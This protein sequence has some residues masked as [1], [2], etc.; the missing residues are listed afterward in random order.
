MKNIISPRRLRDVVKRAIFVCLTEAERTPRAQQRE[1]IGPIPNDT[2]VN[3][4]QASK[5]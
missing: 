3:L 2:R 5:C 4:T 1:E